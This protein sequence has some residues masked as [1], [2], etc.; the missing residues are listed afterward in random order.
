MAAADCSLQCA[1]VAIASEACNEVG[2]YYHHVPVGGTCLRCEVPAIPECSSLFASPSAPP[3]LAPPP[4]AIPPRP[5][6]SPAPPCSPSPPAPPLDPRFRPPLAPPPPWPPSLPPS[7]A[8]RLAPLELELAPPDN[9]AATLGHQSVATL[10]AFVDFL[11]GPEPST[12]DF[13]ADS[14]L[15]LRANSACV[16][17]TGTTLALRTDSTA[18][19]A[20]VTRATVTANLALGESLLSATL[21]LSIVRLRNVTLELGAAPR[22]KMGLRELGRVQCSTGRQRARP[23]VTATL[24]TGSTHDVTAH[25]TYAS[26]DPSMVVVVGAGAD[27]QLAGAAAAG[28]AV[29]TTTFAGMS[30]SVPLALSDVVANITAISI[31]ATAS[32]ETASSATTSNG[33]A[34]VSTSP[35]L[36]SATRGSVFAMPVDL[37]LSD[38]AVLAD[39]GSLDWL[40]P[41]EML[42]FTSSHEAV[43]VSSTGNLT[44]LGNH[45]EPVRVEVA[46]CTP[47]APHAELALVPNLLAGYRGIDLG[48]NVGLQF[49]LGSD[50]KLL[51]P[52]LVNAAAKRLAAFHVVVE[53]DPLLLRA[54][55]SFQGV[56]NGSGAD[57]FLDS[58]VATFDDP[59]GAV[60]LV[61]SVMATPAPSGAVQLSTLTF[62]LMPNASG[63]TLLTGRMIGLV[64]CSVCDGSDDEDTVSLGD[65]A[66]AAGYVHLGGRRRRLER[67]IDAVSAAPRQQRALAATGTC[68]T[69]AIG[70]GT[71]AGDVNGDCNFDIRDV[72]MA[73]VLL[74]NGS[75]DIPARHNGTQL[76]AWQRK[77]LDPN[78]DGI[79][80]PDDSL[81][82]LKVLARK[83]RFLVD[84]NLTSLLRPWATDDVTLQVRLLTDAGVP[85]DNQTMVKVEFEYEA[86]AAS[87][88]FSVGVPLLPTNAGH[89][90]A[91]ARHLGDGIFAATFSLLSGA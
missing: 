84:Y 14:R 31:N 8:L 21:A 89:W 51:V 63:V 9:A 26:S 74:R 83:Y 11:D 25:S 5:P 42:R 66:A 1:V 27:T 85:A 70:A 61:G 77:Q 64:T 79:F 47:D 15:V 10:S 73:S 41:S 49:E 78:L 37:H 48:A 68:C 17:I 62:E 57:S 58:V 20:G 29:I 46:L 81:Y 34:T 35:T 55:S 69:G 71:V 13:S 12:Q 2:P 6:Q 60:T 65:D 28:G 75:S 30:S 23:L 50:R 90:H 45:Y 39:A 54:V 44:L 88:A 19:C 59:V 3:P 16:A 32:N 87:A 53:A 82:L 18:W 56:T 7:T 86:T 72:R 24:S 91:A 43:A 52:V 80:R 4:P 40:E 67:L 76:C 36:L 22:G 38:G 33:S